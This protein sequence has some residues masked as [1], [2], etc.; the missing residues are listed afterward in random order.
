MELSR[1]STELNLENASLDEVKVAM[2]CTPTK[3]G[4]QRLQI[5]RWLFEGRSRQEVAQLS[6]FSDRQ[7]LR[8]IR[9]FND[10]GLDGLIP[11]RSSGRA[12][13]VALSLLKQ[14]VEPVMDD[15]SLAG[16]THWSAVKLHGWLR[17]RLQVDLGYSTTVRYL[18]ELRY[19]L[20]V[21]RPWPLHQDPEAREAFCQ[22]LQIWQEDPCIDLWFGDE[23]GI[24]GDPRPR[25]Q[26]TQIGRVRH[27]P[28]LGEH[29]RHNVIGA[30]RP[31]D[32]RICTLLTNLCDTDTFQAF[33]NE[34]A[35]ENPPQES[36]RALLVLDNAGW[37][38]TKRLNWHHFE[39]AYLPARSPDLNPIER[40]WL[41]LK[42]DWF[43]GWVAKSSP[44]LQERL[45]EA[46][47]STFAHPAMVQRQCRPK[48]SL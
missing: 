34:L 43:N 10:F 30:V 47:Q 41:R 48:L 32:G 39:P 19:K 23:C 40:L 46:L 6:Y 20:K 18:H 45:I 15:P 17:E 36:R 26:W 31:R 21:P 2:A 25:R 29:I 3:K 5:L 38:K 4:Y 1:P 12:R 22:Q 14:H 28:Y 42:A 9:A 37:H 33:L 8:Y 35:R 7:I 27:S 13:K 24:E 44:Q 16:Q 11:G